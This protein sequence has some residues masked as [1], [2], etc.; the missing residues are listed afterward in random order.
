MVLV[1]NN[2]LSALAKVDRLALLPTVFDTVAT[3][4]A[5]VDELDSA[6]TA[7]YSFVEGIDAVKSY[8]GVGSRSL[9]RPTRSCGRPTTSAITR[10]RGPTHI[11]SRSPNVASGGC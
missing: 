10:S 2:V 11:V 3:P 9:P 8:E 7:G 1:D 5:V 4:P 6:R